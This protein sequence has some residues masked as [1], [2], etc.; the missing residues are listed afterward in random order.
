MRTMDIPAECPIK[1]P[2]FFVDHYGTICDQLVAGKTTSEIGDGLQA[3]GVEANTENVRMALSNVLSGMIKRQKFPDFPQIKGF[4]HRTS[5]RKKPSCAYIGSTQARNQTTTIES[6][7]TVLE[8]KVEKVGEKLKSF[9]QPRT[10]FEIAMQKLAAINRVV[11][12]N[13]FDEISKVKYIKAELN[14]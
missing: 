7:D 2:E 13:E 6:A 14:N 3:K 5:R 10:Q 4:E 11:E 12:S 1:G 8:G 9:N